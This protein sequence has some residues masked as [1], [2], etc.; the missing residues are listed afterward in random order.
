LVFIVGEKFS[1]Y[2]A[3]ELSKFIK[4]KLLLDV[5]RKIAFLAGGKGPLSP[6]MK[7]RKKILESAANIGTDIHMYGGKGSMK[8]RKGEWED[9]GRPRSSIESSYDEYMA[10]PTY[11]EYTIDAEMEG[12]DAVILSCGSDPG[13][14]ALREA[15]KIPV[16]GPGTSAMHLC[17]LLGKRFCRLLTHRTNRQR[18]SLEPFEKHNGLMKWVSSRD[19]GLTVLEVRDNPEKT[20]ELCLEKGKEAIKFD[21]VDALTYS[22]MSIAFLDIDERLSKELQIPVINPAKAAIRMAET[23]VD[24]GLTHSKL[25]FPTPKRLLK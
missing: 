14:D 23:C 22:C 13:L 17:S 8:T 6:E 16:I 10:I 15:V 4:Y 2:V 18:L 1:F 11:L 25:G 3:Y 7:R 9:D 19:L 24:L 5:M 12:Y 20:F 21:S